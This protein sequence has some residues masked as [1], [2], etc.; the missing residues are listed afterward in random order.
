MD[1]HFSSLS[2][3]N[4]AEYRRYFAACSQK[5]SDYSFVNLWGWG[6]EYGLEWA[7]C[8]SYVLLRQTIPHTMYWAPV[9]NWEQI[10]WEAFCEILPQDVCFIRIP[11]NLQRIW[12]QRLPGI[13]T[14]EC[15]EHWDYLYDVHE[16]IELKGRKFHKKKN[17]LNQFM[18]DYEAKFVLLDEKTVECALAL[19]TDWFLWRDTENDQ[20]LNA[21]NR[22]IIKIMHD[23]SDLPGLLGAGLVVDEK[24]IAYTIAEALDDHSVVIHFEKGCPQ[25]KG[26]YQAIN[27]M[28]LHECC[29]GFQW[30]NR[31]QDLGDEGLRKAKLSY[32]PADFLKKYRVC[33]KGNLD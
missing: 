29:Q 12:E 21:E 16:L 1:I 26:V 3:H 28:F 24:M 10:D 14:R 23:W 17:L 31:E 22:A 19:Q 33:L 7:F 13:Q 27:Q 32:N 15:R 30:V 25:F 8:D 9:G 18:R 6:K 20:T 4:Q 2:L 5:P 11:E